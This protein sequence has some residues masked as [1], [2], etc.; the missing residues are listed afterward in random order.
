MILDPPAD[1]DESA[2]E[3]SGSW[4]DANGAWRLWDV[5][6]ADEVSDDSSAPEYDSLEACFGADVVA[7][8]RVGLIPTLSPSAIRDPETNTL[9]HSQ[10]RMVL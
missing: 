10:C 3:E 7:A 1:E 8:P 9:S 6:S 4:S 5:Y 2:D